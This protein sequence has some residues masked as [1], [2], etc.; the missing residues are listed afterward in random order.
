MC[1]YWISLCDQERQAI[2]KPSP[3]TIP[4]TKPI[5]KEN[6]YMFL[7]SILLLEHTHVRYILRHT[8][9]GSILQRLLCYHSSYFSA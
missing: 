2:P 5:A 7:M 6:M 1:V 3:L 4:P 8:K 9:A